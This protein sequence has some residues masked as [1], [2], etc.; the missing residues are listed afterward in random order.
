MGNTFM[1]LWTIM[2]VGFPFAFMLLFISNLIGNYNNKDM[3]F[4]LIST[5]IFI[6]MLYL[7]RQELYLIITGQIP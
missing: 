6:V 3:F 1:F 4:L 7:F 5:I 2:W